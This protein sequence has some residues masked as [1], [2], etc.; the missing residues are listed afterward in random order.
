MYSLKNILSKS[1]VPVLVLLFS[2]ASC[3]KGGEPTPISSS[4]HSSLNQSARIAGIVGGDDNEDDDDSDQKDTG[5][6]RGQ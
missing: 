1:L 5:P 3:S 2:L 6:S 4:N